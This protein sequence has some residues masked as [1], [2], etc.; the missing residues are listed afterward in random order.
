MATK[1]SS[2]AAFD[3]V[4]DV[5]LERDDSTPLKRALLQQG[6][7]DIHA[8][9]ILSD[10]VINSLTHDD[11]KGK[12]DMPILKFERHSSPPSSTS[13]S[14]GIISKILWGVTGKVSPRKNST[15]SELTQPI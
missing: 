1:Y 7:N 5:I 4:L 13:S 14:T 12:V 11:P 10:D 9:A 15:T 8:L 2:K 6:Y 3:H